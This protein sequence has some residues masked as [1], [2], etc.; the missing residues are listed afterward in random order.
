MSSTYSIFNPR[1]QS[2]QLPS[3]ILFLCGYFCRTNRVR[4]DRI[5]YEAGFESAV[6][7]ESNNKGTAVEFYFKRTG[8][9]WGVDRYAASQSSRL[10]AMAL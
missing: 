9:P 4:L 8:W 6:H 1:F 3:K 5:L 2:T 7:Q 10:A